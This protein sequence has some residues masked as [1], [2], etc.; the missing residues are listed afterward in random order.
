MDEPII[1]RED[2]SGT[3]EVLLEALH[4]RD[5]S[6]DMLTISMVLGNA[7]AIEMAV[8][9]GLG[10]AFVSKLAAAR[11]LALGR[12][13]EIEVEGMSLRRAIFLARNRRFPTTRAQ[14]EFWDFVKQSNLEFKIVA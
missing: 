1:L 10:V 13:V 9:E 5:I 12:V 8:E 4:D 11:G 2:G 3:R 6:A 14:S 7:E